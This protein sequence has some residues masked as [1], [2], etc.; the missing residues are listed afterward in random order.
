VAPDD[1][2]CKPAA[3]LQQLLDRAA[4]AGRL[5]TA[6]KTRPVDARPA[7]PGEVVVTVI[8]GE[9]QETQSPPARP[10][11]WVVR[12]RCPETGHEQYLVAARSFGD[13]YRATGAAPAQGWQEFRPIGKDV[14]FV[15]VDEE[16]GS[17]S[18]TAPWGQRM[19]AHPGDV[20]VQDPDDPRRIYRVA[21]ASFDCTYDVVG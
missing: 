3:E 6:R 13:T 11:D 2:P 17:F 8:K 1:L 14:R 18:F 15:A 9:G 7:R 12:N 10:G 19:V 20:L 5:R 21:R 16:A 4:A